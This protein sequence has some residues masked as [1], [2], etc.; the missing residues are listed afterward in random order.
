MPHDLVTLLGHERESLAVRDGCA[1]VV[2][3]RGHNAP[4]V[5]E[6]GQMQRADTLSVAVALEPHAHGRATLQLPHAR[7]LKVARVADGHAG[8]RERR[9]RRGAGRLA[10]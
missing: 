3:K 2:D 1:E 9:V 4:V 7:M 8:N 5:A 6:R 10:G